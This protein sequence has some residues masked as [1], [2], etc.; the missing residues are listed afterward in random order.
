MTEREAKAAKVR[1]E[2]AT[3]PFGWIARAI[4]TGE[5]AGTLKVLIDPDGERII[6][7]SIVGAEAGELV[8]VFAALMQAGAPART[9]VNMECVHPAFAEGLQSLL[10]RLE[11]YAPR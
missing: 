10:M 5:T 9:V 3:M 2:A 4:E 6:G 8:H 1:Y 11:R 7:A